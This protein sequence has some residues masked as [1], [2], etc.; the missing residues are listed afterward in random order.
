HAARAPAW[1]AEHG[2]RFDVVMVCRHYVASEFLP[3]LRRHAPQARLVFDT[4]DL[5]YLRE[6]R[7]ADVTG[8]STLANA[9]AR[10]RRQELAVIAAADTT[11]VVSAVERDVLATDAPEA[12]VEVLSNLHSVAGPGLPFEQRHDLVFVGGFR[13]PPNVDAA[14]WFASEVMPLVL[15]RLPEVRFHCIGADVPPEVAA[16]AAMP[17]V[18]VHGYVRD[19]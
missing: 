5:H 10:T 7:T 15:A 19:I 2:A 1:L 16:L 4:I 14:R 18:T 8:D 9:A 3:L 13:H 17:G 6:A 12:R 11:L